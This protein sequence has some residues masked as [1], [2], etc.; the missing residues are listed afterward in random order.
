MESNTVGQGYRHK[1]GIE[2]TLG[3]LI[4]RVT[5]ILLSTIMLVFFAVLGGR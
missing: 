4:K 1:D 2:F 3:L 5:Y